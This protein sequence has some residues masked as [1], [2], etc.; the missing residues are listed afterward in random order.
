MSLRGDRLLLPEDSGMR[1][2]P[3]FVRV[4]LVPPHNRDHDTGD[5]HLGQRSWERQ[6]GRLVGNRHGLPVGSADNAVQR[7]AST[8]LQHNE[9]AITWGGTRLYNDSIPSV[10]TLG[11]PFH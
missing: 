9:P 3:V 4:S 8:F 7:T 6:H 5:G 1:R 11:R 10:E 2:F